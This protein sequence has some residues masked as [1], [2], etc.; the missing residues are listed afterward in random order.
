MEARLWAWKS[1]IG[2][3]ILR[4]DE[5]RKEDG[6]TDRSCGGIEKALLGWGL[7][8]RYLSGISAGHEVTP[9]K[10]IMISQ[11]AVGWGNERPKDQGLMR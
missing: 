7:V 2:C 1:R 9:R 5:I 4:F 6:R 8:R 11:E 3:R 10:S